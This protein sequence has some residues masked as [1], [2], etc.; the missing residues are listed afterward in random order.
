MTTA[1]GNLNI[2]YLEEPQGI[3]REFTN[4]LASNAVRIGNR[5]ALGFYRQETMEQMA[6]EYMDIYP[7]PNDQVD[8]LYGWIK[9]LPWPNNGYLSLAFNW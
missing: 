8:I 2:D 6:T 3:I 1:I 9:A 4:Y 7:V 5:C